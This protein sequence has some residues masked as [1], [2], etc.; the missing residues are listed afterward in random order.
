MQDS[1]RAAAEHSSEGYVLA[2]GAGRTHY[3]FILDALN[4]GAVLIVVDMRFCQEILKLEAES[5]GRLILIKEDLKE[6]ERI[7]SKLAGYN[8]SAL[9]P[10]PLGRLLS[11]G[12]ILKAVSLP[13]PALPNSALAQVRPGWPGLRTKAP[14]L[15][16]RSD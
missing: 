15:S 3:P 16:L 13:I 10:V 6:P 11:T 7:I 4:F 5:G 2:L 14:A 9:L 12:C 8:I 1:A